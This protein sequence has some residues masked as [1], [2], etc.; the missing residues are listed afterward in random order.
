M[1]IQ[2]QHEARRAEGYDGELRG[3]NFFTLTVTLFSTLLK[4][5]KCHLQQ[6]RQI[7]SVLKAINQIPYTRLRAKGSYQCQSQHVL[8]VGRNNS[9]NT[10][11]TASA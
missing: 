4:G 1:G 9:N 8:Y 2:P 10:L 7:T 3:S 11:F 6:G 5:P